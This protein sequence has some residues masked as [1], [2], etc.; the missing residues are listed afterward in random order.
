MQTHPVSL[1]S[2]M[3]PSI[4]LDPTPSSDDQPKKNSTETLMQASLALD[5]IIDTKDFECPICHEIMN[6]PVSLSCG[7]NFEREQIEKW[8]KIKKQ[9]PCCNQPV[10]PF[11]T[12]NLFLKNAIRTWR[13]KADMEKEEVKHKHLLGIEKRHPFTTIS[14]EEEIQV[15]INEA[16]QIAQQ[17]ENGRSVAIDMIINLQE[18]QGN[19]PIISQVLHSLFHMPQ[20]PGRFPASDTSRMPS[21]HTITIDDEPSEEGK[22]I[23]APFNQN[24]ISPPRTS[25]AIVDIWRNQGFSSALAVLFEWTRDEPQRP[26]YQQWLEA[27]LLSNPPFEERD[28]TQTEV[29]RLVHQ[30]QRSIHPILIAPMPSFHTL[31]TATIPTR[32]VPQS[33]APNHLIQAPEI[34]LKRKAPAALR[35]GEKDYKDYP[36]AGESDGEDKRQRTDIAPAIINIFELAKVGKMK[37]FKQALNEETRKVK[38]GEGNSLLHCVVSNERNVPFIAALLNPKY[39]DLIDV[40]NHEGNTALHIAVKIDCLRLVEKLLKYFPSLNI[41]NQQGKTAEQMSQSRKIKALFAE[42]RN[43]TARMQGH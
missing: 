41:K 4:I 29:P 5:N 9:C 27:L 3:Y 31:G 30:T 1:S 36:I 6:D 11:L 23:D 14:T 34:H 12:P 25:D 17:G 26:D 21:T 8:L 37:Y 10:Q 20:M 16:K 7:H 24:R 39:E 13:K 15:K 28:R 19:L 35:E 42:H 38:D 40:T 22:Q 18:E 2:G 33:L 32:M 43:L